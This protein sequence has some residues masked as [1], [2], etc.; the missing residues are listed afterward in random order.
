MAFDGK[1]ILFFTPNSKLLGQI[2]GRPAHE[3]TAEGVREPFPYAVD[4]LRMTQPL[5]PT[6]VS[7]YKRSPAH[8]LDSAD[9]LDI[10]I[11]ALDILEGVDKGL[12][13]GRA[14]TLHRVGRNADRYP[15]HKRDHPRDIGCIGRLPDTADD[16]FLDERW[17]QV[18]PGDDLS[19]DQFAQLLR[20]HVL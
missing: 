10:R 16:H 12:K 8:A 17:I 15:G 18:G 1:A 5:P 19:H 13:P 11:L 2:F 14:I 6:H 9:D 3:L 7:G 20:R 4:E